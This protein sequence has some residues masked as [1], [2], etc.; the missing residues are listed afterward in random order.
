MGNFIKDFTP[1]NAAVILSNKCSAACR[2]CCFGCNP[3]KDTTLT[4]EEI[5]NFVDEVVATTN[6]RFIVWT[7]GEA[8]MLGERLCEVLDYAQQRGLP[9]RIVSNGYWATSSNVAKQRLTK[10]KLSGLRELNLST[11]DNH[12]EWVTIEKVL[13]AARESLRLGINTVVSIETTKHS[14]FKEKDLRQHPIY[15]SIENEGLDNRLEIVNAA[16]VSFHRD[17]EYEYE[18][19]DDAEINNGCDHLFK[20]IGLNPK[21]EL[22]A[23]CGLT[24]D[25]IPEMNLGKFNQDSKLKQAYDQQKDD[26]MKR[27]L[28]VAGPINIMRMVKQWDKTIQIPK[29]AHYCQ[30]CA[31][32]FQSEDI[33][34]CILTNF[35]S[36][37]DE[38]NQKFENKIKI[39]E[40]LKLV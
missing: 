27:W 33:R 6:A 9:S 31:Y 11:G 36:I 28:F 21:S 25:Y 10:L 34:Q 13:T 18:D 23:C 14:H 39:N 37:K 4:N 7:G 38:I 30:T 19:I 17:Q 32:I 20:F 22:V 15:Q 24:V 8:F 26:F 3:R 16:W 29:F 5:F 1:T 12:Q 40:E 35:S 2:E